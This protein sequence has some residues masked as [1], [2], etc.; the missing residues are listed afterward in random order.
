[1]EMA[2]RSVDAA[3]KDYRD[4]LWLAR[5]CWD[6]HQRVKAGEALRRSIEL[7]SEHPDVWLAYISYLAGTEPVE[8]PTP[9]KTITTEQAIEEAGRKLPKDQAALVLA[10][11]YTITGHLDRANN[12]T[13]PRCRRSPKTPI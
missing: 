10:R 8:R 13:W 1:M 6:S 11:G 4:H 12:C 5:I 7:G 9:L 3:S 2:S